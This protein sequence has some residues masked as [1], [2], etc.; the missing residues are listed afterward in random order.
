MVAILRDLVIDAGNVPVGGCFHRAGETVP[1]KVQAITNRIVV[2]LIRCERL[3]IGNRDV[4]NP[5]ALRVH[6]LNLRGTQAV[7]PGSNGVR[8][9]QPLDGHARANLLGRL[10]YGSS[11][12]VGNRG[13]IVL[14]DSVLHG[15][16]GDDAD[17]TLGFVLPV[18]FIVREKE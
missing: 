8:R 14:D 15:G 3:Q 11:G 17:R 4:A 5:D 7:I 18:P 10:Y 12:G 1:D 2:R 9:G 6:P 13:A 16:A